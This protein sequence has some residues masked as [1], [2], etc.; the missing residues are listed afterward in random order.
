MIKIS[1]DLIEEKF[2]KFDFQIENFGFFKA[3]IRFNLSEAKWIPAAVRQRL[4]AKFPHRLSKDGDFVV[5]SDRTTVGSLNVA[6]C[7]DKLRNSLWECVDEIRTKSPKDQK[8]PSAKDQEGSPSKDKIAA[9]PR[10]QQGT[11]AKDKK[12]ASPR[13]QE[14]KSAKDQQN[15]L[16]L[17]AR[18]AKEARR[19]LAITKNL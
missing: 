19:R 13:D 14:E 15:D 6:D 5:R 4:G 16:E 12:E 3:E 2:E 17:E 8:Q 10:D 18:H 7:L 11:S 9:S 1:F